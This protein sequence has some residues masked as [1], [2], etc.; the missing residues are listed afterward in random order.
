[1]AYINS[2]S[3]DTARTAALKDVKI[4]GLGIGIVAR[5]Y[6]V[7]R[8]TI[9]RWIKKWDELN[10]HIQKINY[11]RP[12]RNDTPERKFRPGSYRWRIPI[13]PCA[14]KHHP[15]R[16]SPVLEQ[17]ILAYRKSTGKRHDAFIHAAMT[18]DG[19]NVNLSAIK[20]VISRHGLQQ[21]KK[22]KHRT[23]CPRPY[24]EYPGDLVAI[25]TIHYFNLATGRKLYVYT[26]IDIKTRLTYALCSSK[27]SQGMAVKAINE[28]E[29]LFGF[30]LRVIQADNG[31]EFG[32]WFDDRVKSG[33]RIVRHTRPHRP[34]DNAH[35][36]RFNRTIQDECIG[37][38]WNLRDTV[39]LL[40]KR[41]AKY[42]DLYNN[43]RLHSS[44]EYK[45]PREYYL[46][47]CIGR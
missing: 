43:H 7:H 5:K 12:T 9:W 10:K 26:V 11:G 37:K 2:H 17:T 42:I 36:E 14:P 30:K 28:A 24:V 22:L 32:K 38:Y 29:K 40:N 23:N 13:Y 6:G 46:E 47:C 27:I 31:P 35:I 3:M 41:I 45:T 44:I 39:E 34:N 16:I 18:R 8:T 33:G 25:D 15:R 21:V 20:R 4:R 1:M 19:I